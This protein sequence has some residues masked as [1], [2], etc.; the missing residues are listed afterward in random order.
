MKKVIFALLGATAMTLIPTGVNA[1]TQKDY[2][3]GECA[4]VIDRTET[5][6]I[7]S[8][9]CRILNRGTLN[10]NGATINKLSEFN[11]IEGDGIGK[12]GDAAILN[13]GGTINMNSGKVYADYGYGIINR[14]GIVN[15]KG[16]TIHSILHQAIHS[17]SG[18]VNI[19]SG[20]LKGAIGGEEVIYA[21]S[22]LTICGGNFNSKRS[23]LGAEAETQ[24]CPKA[25]EPET[26]KITV[27]ASIKDNT[28][29]KQQNTATSTKSTTST[30]PVTTAKTNT[31]NNPKPTTVAQATEEKKT[32]VKTDEKVVEKKD[33]EVKAEEAK[34]ETSENNEDNNTLIFAVAAIVAVLGVASTAIV[35]NRIRH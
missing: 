29:A 23:N 4:I 7:S 6:N 21:N 11:G 22:G 25:A 17:N 16:G 28:P 20:T 33:E 19:S 10:I 30:K 27:T 35:I 18:K 9:N 1:T 12:F 15:V 5:V 2:G 31:T 24:N 13:D 26:V 3:N 14:G 32:E 34:N 8:T